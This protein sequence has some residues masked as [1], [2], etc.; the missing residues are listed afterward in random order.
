MKAILKRDFK[1]CF[2]TVVG[3]LYIAVSIALYGLYFFAYNLNYG[4]ADVS[5]PLNAITFLFLI[6]VPVLTMRSIAEEKKTKTDQLTLTSPVSVGKIVLAKYFALAAVHTAAVLFIAATPLLL[7]AFGTVPMG[8]NYAAVLGFYLYGLLCIAVGL[9]VSSL[10]ESQVISAVLTF[11]LLFVGYMM[12]SITGIFSTSD[13]ILTKLLSCYDLVTPLDSFLNGC[14]SLKGILYYIT[15]S[16]LFL[17]LTAQSIQKRRFT[18]STKKL[19]LGAYSVGLIAVATALAVVV[20]LFAKELPSAYTELDVTASQLYSL[21]DDTKDILKGLEK[22][23]TVYVIAAEKNADSTVAETL[24]RYEDLSSHI[25]VEYKDPAVN[26]TFY[27]QY[28]EEA[29]SMGSLI[30]TCGDISRVVDASKLYE[31]SFDYTTYTSS[32]TGYDGEGQITS[33]LQYVTNE[34]MPVIYQITGHGEAELAGN[35][36]EAVDKANASLQSV[37]L[38]EVDAIPDDAAAVVI[39]GPSS[40]F[41]ADDADKVAAYMKKGGNVFV[42]ANPQ[43]SGLTNFASVL[44]EYGIELVP[45][46]IAEGDAGHFYQNPFYLLPN[47]ETSSY[48]ASVGSNY[49]FAPYVQGVRY[50]ENSDDTTYTPLLTTSEQAVAKTDAANATTYEYEEGDEKGPFTIA[51]A[52]ERTGEGSSAG[53]LVVY[54]SADLVSDSADQMVSGSNSG[55]FA[56]L[57]TN[58]IGGE[59]GSAVV[60]P[61]KSYEAAKLMVPAF[62]GRMI[63]LGMMIALPILLLA[64]GIVIWAKR[65]KR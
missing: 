36:A 42:A 60:I 1:A 53:R 64:A 9:F 17:F 30:F 45:G 29:I 4:Y 2:Q 57:L 40:D 12:N 31:T 63:G 62:A 15:V 39:N 26:P 61:V 24:K 56:D 49:V 55:M 50:P 32:T 6:T 33:A 43:G 27:Q 35:F 52:A 14:I 21:T 19:K 38:L 20:N 22:D 59:D 3:W 47:V 41:S 8:E 58:F 34:H 23:V 51:V 11:L 7:S 16:A 10:T 54:G 44:S 46:L 48:T 65:R 28:T 25:T 13:N 37:N 5:Y 18:V